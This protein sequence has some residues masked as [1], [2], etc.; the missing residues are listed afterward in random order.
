MTDFIIKFA[1]LEW[2]S[3]RPGFRQKSFIREGERI[4]LLEFSEGFR[5]PE[6]CVKGHRG[7]VLQGELTID[8]NGKLQKFR[9]GEGLSI[10]EG[11]IE[12]RHKV[13]IAPGEKAL[14]IL[15]DKP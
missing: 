13:I 4:R 15:F 9:A 6:W 3:P 14:L 12:S 11:K 7:Y 10:P 5:E 1:S 2:Q 8:F